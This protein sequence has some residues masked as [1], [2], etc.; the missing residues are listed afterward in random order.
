MYLDQFELKLIQICYIQIRYIRFRVKIGW[1]HINR[2]RGRNSSTSICPVDRISCPDMEIQVFLECK[3]P[4]TGFHVLTWRSN[5]CQSWESLWTGFC[6]L[7]RRSKICQTLDSLWTGVHVLT[8]R[9]KFYQTLDSLWTGFH[10]M[11]QRSKFCQT[12]DSL[13]TGFHVLTRR[14]ELFYHKCEW[15]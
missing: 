6:V 1:F 15:M 11:T 4:W 2:T 3:F 7:T 8:Q 14:S 9:S 10:V 12:L 13:W 5:F